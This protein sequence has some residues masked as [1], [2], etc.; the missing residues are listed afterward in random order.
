VLDDEVDEL[1]VKVL[2]EVDQEVLDSWENL[3]TVN[4]AWDGIGWECD[5]L[6]LG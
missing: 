6:N 4:D 3:H 2:A 5:F 1:I